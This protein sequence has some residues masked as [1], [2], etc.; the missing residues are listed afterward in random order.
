MAGR[1]PGG[2]EYTR[3]GAINALAHTCAHCPLRS[4]RFH[5]RS[6]ASTMPL[7]NWVALLT[8]A[9]YSLRAKI[10]GAS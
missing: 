2:G 1:E 6:H 3:G 5:L 10:A 8:T 7:P 4:A 9:K